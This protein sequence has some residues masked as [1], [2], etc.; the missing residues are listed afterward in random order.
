MINNKPVLVMVP[1][2]VPNRTGVRPLN[3]VP[4]APPNTDALDLINV[5]ALEPENIPNLPN[6]MK[7]G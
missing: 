5:G 6:F 7:I 1:E 2:G 4:L 3:P